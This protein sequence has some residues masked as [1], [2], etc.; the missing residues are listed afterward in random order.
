MKSLRGRSPLHLS[1]RLGRVR[2]FS[3][4]SR[5]GTSE[6]SLTALLELLILGSY[7]WVIPMR[8]GIFGQ[9]LPRVGLVN[10]RNVVSGDHWQFWEATE[11]R[12]FGDP[13][14]LQLLYF[15]SRANWGTVEAAL[16]TAKAK[17]TVRPHKFYAVCQNSADIAADLPRLQKT[18]RALSAQTVRQLLSQTVGRRLGGGQAQGDEPDTFFVPPDLQRATPDL[19]TAPNEPTVKAIPAL[20]DWLMD[21]SRQGSR[22]GVLVANAG[23]GKTTV[24]RHLFRYLRGKEGKGRFP[25]L[26]ESDQ[27]AKLSDR[28]SLS[29]WDVWRESLDSLYSS[30]LGRD[31]FEMAVEYGLFLPIFDGF[32]E[33]CTRLGAHFVVGDTL[34]QI[35]QLLEDTEG[36]ILLT[37]RDAFWLDSLASSR[38]NELNHFR[39]LTFNKQQTTKYFENRFR[40]PKDFSKRAVADKILQRIEQI[41]H[42]GEMPG[43]RHRLTAVPLVVTL[44]AECADIEA[45]EAAVLKYGELLNSED[46]LQGLLL[47]FFERERERRKL[48][49][50]PE[51]QLALFSELA[52]NCGDIFSSEQLRLFAAM[53]GITE[54]GAQLQALESHA[55]LRLSGQNYGFR[56]DFLGRYLAAGALI[57]NLLEDP[58]NAKVGAFLESESRGGTDLVDRAVDCVFAH[59]RAEALEKLQRTW[60]KV[61]STQSKQAQS[62]LL[63]LILKSVERER[64]SGPRSERTA[65]IA[66]VLGSPNPQTISNIYVEGTINGLDLRGVTLSDWMFVNAG[67][68][69]C[70]C[71]STTRFVHCTFEGAFDVEDCEDF[72]DATYENCSFGPRAREVVQLNDKLGRIPINPGQVRWTVRLALQVFQTGVG[73]KAI[74]RET[75]RRGRISTSP[76]RKQVWEALEKHGVITSITI[77]GL[78]DDGLQVPDA[79]REEVRLFLSNAILSGDLRDAVKDVIDQ[80]VSPGQSESS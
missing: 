64:S 76:I 54:P 21:D 45:S 70:L 56:F 7:C 48:A 14:V 67:F 19:G 44:A 2:E 63:H 43:P 60:P 10:P 62:G 17:A 30:A 26:V 12:T 37:T 72:G 8:F 11:E 74:P 16:E 69:K 78:L 18:T 4:C 79:R 73:F 3:P 59:H 24:A 57:K 42:A 32:D 31:D 58:T 29:L 9:V 80:L 47:I 51:R 49:L 34:N 68:S 71:D 35:G 40:Q 22:I 23:V 6:G 28:A 61:R 46:P 5:S 13:E 25:I 27:W 41:A 50:T 66:K 33:L 38:R 55:L 53:F 77:K 20:A 1:Q 52:F 75:C 65:A 15:D 39:L 36:R